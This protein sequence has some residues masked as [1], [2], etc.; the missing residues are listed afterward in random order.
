MRKLM[1]N[2]P[3]AEPPEDTMHHPGGCM[4]A[5][6]AY[7]HVERFWSGVRLFSGLLPGHRFHCLYQQ[8]SDQSG[9][10]PAKNAVY[11]PI[12]WLRLEYSNTN[13]E[14]RWLDLLVLQHILPRSC[15]QLLCQL[16]PDWSGIEPLEDLVHIASHRV[17]SQLCHALVDLSWAGLLLPS[18]VFAD[19]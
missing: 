1:S 8:L 18:Y 14:Q 10:Q 7:D 4:W 19:S 3:G 5:K 2:K 16:M 11:S 13:M 12:I 6:H 15:A 17:R 9:S